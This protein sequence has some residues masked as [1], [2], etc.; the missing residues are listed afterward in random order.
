MTHDNNFL[1]HVLEHQEKTRQL[2]EK[3]VYELRSY[4]ELDRELAILG[5]RIDNLENLHKELAASCR[6][7][8]E[9]IERTLEAVKSRHYEDTKRN[10]EGRESIREQLRGEVVV[11]REKIAEID[12]RAAELGARYGAVLG[13]L[14]AI[15]IEGLRWL[16]EGR[17]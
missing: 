1:F 13:V 6:F 11:L 17:K 15:A 3:V 8:R 2:L 10:H 4:Q 5:T 14:S 7:C 12:K 16:L 9:G